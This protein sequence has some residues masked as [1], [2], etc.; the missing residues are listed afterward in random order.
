M[1]QVRQSTVTIL[2]STS[3]STASVDLCHEQLVGIIM[4]AAWD[5][6]ALTFQ[7]SI[8][9]STWGEVRS[10]GAAFTVASAD[11]IASALVLLDSHVTPAIRFLKV[12]S[13]TSGAAVNQTADRV[14]TLLTRDL[15]E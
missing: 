1:Q 7:G 6:A 10:A 3:L 5:A 15:V 8:D 12:R 9:G 2:N 14:I 11:A 4:P 13:G